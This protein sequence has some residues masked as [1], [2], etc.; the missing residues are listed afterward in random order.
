M[1]MIVYYLQIRMHIHIQIH[2]Q[3]VLL[4]C[5]QALRLHRTGAAVAMTGSVCLSVYL[6]VYLSVCLSVFD[7]VYMSLDF[8]SV[9]LSI[10]TSVLF[11]S[12]FILFYDLFLSA[13]RMTGW[14]E[15]DRW[16]EWIN[17]QHTWSGPVVSS[18]TCTC[19]YNV[20]SPNT[21]TSGYNQGN[22]CTSGFVYYFFVFLGWLLVLVCVLGVITTCSTVT[23][24]AMHWALSFLG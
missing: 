8:S 2:M 17:L 3:C 7:F 19:G 21:C 1:E 18:N 16:M 9:C 24:V 6:S 15:A 14:I 20:V 22:L 11:L 10:C 23:A 12:I 13:L 5:P 4:D